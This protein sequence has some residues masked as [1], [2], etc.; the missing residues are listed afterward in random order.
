MLLTKLKKLNF[1]FL[2]IIIL[3]S[4]IGFIS[5]YSAANGNIDPWAKKQAIRFFIT[6]IF[7]IIISLID[8][9]YLYKHA[10]IF[11]FLSL[12]LLA[13]VEIADTFG[14]RADRWIRIFGISIQPSELIKITIILALSKYY[15]SLK[16]DLLGK[17]SSLFIPLC[18]IF[19]PFLFVLL[20]PDLGTSIMILL[21]G[22]SILFIAGIRLWKFLL[23]LVMSI[24]AMP[25]LWNNLETYQ[26]KRFLA[27]L[28]PESDP[29]GSGYHLIQSKIALGSG[30]LS[31]KGFLQGTQSYLDS[32]MSVLSSLSSKSP[33][34]VDW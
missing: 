33:S 17:I 11:F 1:L 16:F 3:L 28:N 18:I 31:G 9:K 29:L 13:S 7:L 4:F 20:Q 6:F 34:P 8:I 32:V 23:G 25:L 26:Q 22:F 27:F 21:L 19:I 12:L 24:I 30:G 10:Y 15:H 2:F 14:F 5:L